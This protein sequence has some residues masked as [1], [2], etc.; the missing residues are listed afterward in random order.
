MRIRTQ[1]ERSGPNERGHLVNAATTVDQLP[2][3]PVRHAC[4]RKKL[5]LKRFSAQRFVQKKVI[6]GDAILFKFLSWSIMK[7]SKMRSKSKSSGLSFSKLE[8]R[9]LLAS[10]FHDPAT[11]TLY[12]AGDSG[13]NV[14]EVS[15]NNGQVVA[16]VDD[17]QFSAASSTVTDIVFIGYAGDD[18]F[19]NSSSRAVSMFGHLGNDTLIGGSGNDNLV[20]GPGDDI[21]NGM[22]GNDRVVGVGGNDT[23]HGGDGEDRI[24][25]TAGENLIHGGDGN[26]TIYGGAEADEI[27][28]DD[29]DDTVYALGGMNKIFGGKGNDALTGGN[30]A[31]EI[32][33]GEGRDA[34]LALGGDDVLY[35]G[36]GGT[37]GGKFS[38]GDVVRG[39]SGN[40]QFFGG[41]GLD[42]FLGGEGHDIMT[43]GSG[44]NRMFGHDGDDTIT[45]GSKQNFIMGGN[46]EDKVVIKE[47]YAVEKVVPQS[48]GV[49]VSG[50][51]MGNVRWLEFNDRII[52]GQQAVYGIADETNFNSLNNYRD[53]RN[54]VA[55]SKPVDLAD[56]ARDWS[57]QMAKNDRLEHSPSSEQVKLLTNGRTQAGEN[58][59]WVTDIGQSEAE[60]AEYFHDQWRNSS[61][62]NA[63]MIKQTFQEVGI[64]VVKSGGK[65]WATQI[66]VG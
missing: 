2:K 34:I 29:G 25:G 40:D 36:P 28:G 31:D 61:S 21:V 11:G 18:T 5:F 64:G 20:G 4:C 56:Y 1:T 32:N 26:D 38:E 22:G 63:N 47:N 39:N 58:I 49:T 14:G 45:V 30:D 6:K 8:P 7:H 15:V 23:L 51:F 27:H 55:L 12:V 66:Y 16:S 13:D 42:I 37:T 50:D 19:V 52:S 46:G 54:R 9:Q 10:I 35:S 62:H 60:V 3:T 57:L 44:E 48:N 17:K 53:S 24:F 33:G 41:G 59:G 43:G 65:W